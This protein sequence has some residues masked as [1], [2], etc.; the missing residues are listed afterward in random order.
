[1]FA[2]LESKS[3]LTHP[4]VQIYS[5]PE[6]PTGEGVKT[7]RLLT[8]ITEILLNRTI[9]TSSKAGAN[10]VAKEI[11]AKVMAAWIVSE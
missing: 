9:F 3:G 6:V 10:L 11:L 4:G 8:G 5:P 7:D 1:M 2:H